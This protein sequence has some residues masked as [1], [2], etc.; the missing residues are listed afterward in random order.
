MTPPCFV[1]TPLSLSNHHNNTSMFH[2]D[3]TVFQVWFTMT[4]RYNLD[5]QWK[6]HV[7]WWHHSVSQWCRCNYQW[8]HHVSWWHNCVSSR[9]HRMSQWHYRSTTTK[10][11]T[12]AP[13]TRWHHPMWGYHVPNTITHHFTAH[14]SSVALHTKLHISAHFAHKTLQRFHTKISLTRSQF[15]YLI[16]ILAVYPSTT[17]PQLKEP[18]KT[19]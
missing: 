4:P 2:I 3:T 11:D 13:K 18:W 5:S 10:D 8:H 17:N 9:H 19:M 1:M 12:T 15:K 6:H 14:T 7:S 16:S